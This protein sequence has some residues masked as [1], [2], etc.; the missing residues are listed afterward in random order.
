VHETLANLMLLLIAL[1][2]AGVAL[3]SYR[4]HENLVRSMITGRKRAREPGDIA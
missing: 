4:H 3:A 1:H 2:V